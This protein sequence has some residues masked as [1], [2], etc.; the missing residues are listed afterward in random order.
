MSRLRRKI[1]FDGWYTQDFIASHVCNT[2]KGTWRNSSGCWEEEY[3]RVWY[4]EDEDK[5]Y[6][7]FPC[8]YCYT[9]E[10]NVAETISQK[11]RLFIRRLKWA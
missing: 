3:L 11:I 6:V 1:R 5:T 4:Q 2:L 7:H 9:W 8:D 10:G